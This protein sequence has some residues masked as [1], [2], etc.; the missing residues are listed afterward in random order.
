MF[1]ILTSSNL[2]K[3]GVLTQKALF[4]SFKDQNCS[5]QL[6]KIYGNNK[7]LCS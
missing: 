4:N 2:N 1:V 3:D 6:N 5:A 7:V